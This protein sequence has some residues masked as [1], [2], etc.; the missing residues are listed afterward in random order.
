MAVVVDKEVVYLSFDQRSSSGTNVFVRQII[1][2]CIK[3][4]VNIEMGDLIPDKAHVWKRIWI[5]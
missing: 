2:L 1:I 5:M 3:F 4:N